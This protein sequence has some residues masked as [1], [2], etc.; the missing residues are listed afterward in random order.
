MNLF[1]V[2][3]DI[4]THQE[5][6]HKAAM[7]RLME[8]ISHADVQKALLHAPEP[9]LKVISDGKKPAAEVTSIVSRIAGDMPH[10]KELSRQI[11]A[12]IAENQ[13]LQAHVRRL[14]NDNI[15]LRAALR[16]GA[17]I[18]Q[19]PKRRCPLNDQLERDLVA[20]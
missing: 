8:I 13:R 16:R 3:M 6:R 4:V 19:K 5:K 12:L 14:E 9:I 10:P 18:Q 2:E 11:D 7:A 20:E 1:H 17:V 15:R